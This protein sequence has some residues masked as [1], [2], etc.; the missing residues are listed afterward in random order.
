MTSKKPKG[1]VGVESFQDRLRLRLP[2]QVCKGRSRYLYLGLA[3]TPKNRKIAQA[4]AML[5]ESDIV[6]ERFDPTLD[7]YRPPD[8]TPAIVP[9][10]NLTL[11]ELWQRYVAFKSNTLSPTTLNTDF[12][13]ITNH[14][15]A[16]PTAEFTQAHKIRDSLLGRLSPD[17]ARRVLMQ[18]KACCTWAVGEGLIESN[19]FVNLPSIRV[20]KSRSINPFSRQERDLIIQAFEQSEYYS[21]YTPFVKFLFWT[22]CRTSEAVGLQWQHIGPSLEFI[23]FEEALVGKIRKETKTHS[24]RKFPTNKALKALLESIQPAQVYPNTPVFVSKEG[25]T[26]DP[27]NFLNRA[28]RSVM[29]PLPIKYRPQYNTRHTFITLCLEDSIPVTQVAAWV[30]NSPKTIWTHY[31]GLVN[32]LEVPEP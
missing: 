27:H 13:K 8:Y 15:Q 9:A 26:V 6:F 23:S 30:G 24:N 32:L 5:I 29:K 14:I 25:K 10:G 19:P 16:L 3:D 18:I 2:R 7:K 17:A 22:G 1:T 11:P 12:R 28:W 31:A 4:K 20:A 21:Y